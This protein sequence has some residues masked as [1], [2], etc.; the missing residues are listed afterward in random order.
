M[1]SIIELSLEFSES[2]ERPDFFELPDDIEIFSNYLDSKKHEESMEIFA[3]VLDPTNEKYKDVG[4]F[5][6]FQMLMV[7]FLKGELYSNPFHPGPV[8][9][10]TIHLLKNLILV[11]EAGFVTTESQPGECGFSRVN[12]KKV[13]D[14]S[15]DKIKK[16]HRIKPFA[17]Y[18]KFIEEEQ[19]AYMGGFICD[20][21][22]ITKLEKYLDHC[23]VISIKL[24]E[25]ISKARIK[26]SGDID[27]YMK[28]G[29]LG[30]SRSRLAG[31]PYSGYE[32]KIVLDKLANSDLLSELE[33][34][35][36]ILQDPDDV[37]QNIYSYLK[38][39]CYYVNVVK[40]KKCRKLDVEVLRALRMR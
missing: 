29:V 15:L 35:N 24:S 8:D 4:M 11:N 37:K 28:E 3:E 13:T 7:M 27:K 21:R 33:L 26:I 39:N 2:K 25:P 14:K 32:L 38:N 17:N 36:E 1:T 40:L 18:G 34:F 31:E 20:H 9:S 12:Y 16:L 22:L 5:A 23:A 19:R 6:R 10:E 30:L